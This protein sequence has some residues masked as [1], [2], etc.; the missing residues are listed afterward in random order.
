M[1]H[2]LFKT[3]RDIVHGGQK[4]EEKSVLRGEARQKVDLVCLQEMKECWRC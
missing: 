4:G 1:T 3:A 2:L